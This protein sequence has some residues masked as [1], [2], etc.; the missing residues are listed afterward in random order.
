MPDHA[1]LLAHIVAQTRQ[2]VEFLVAQGELSRPDGNVILNK[3]PTA[4]DIS[5]RE[6][7]DNTRRMALPEAPAAPS[8]PSMP[9]VNNARSPPPP[10]P[11]R[12]TTQARTLWAYNE[13]GSEPNDLSFRAGDVIEIVDETNADWWTGRYNGR[14]GL[15]PSN[16][17]E[18]IPSSSPPSYP[19][20]NNRTFSAPAGPPSNQNYSNTGYASPPPPNP[21]YAGPPPPQQYGAPAPYQQYPQ[22]VA[23]PPPQQQVVQEAPQQQKPSRFGG[24]GLGNLLATSAVGGVG[25][26]AG[27]AVGSGIVNAIF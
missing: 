22:Q 10:A 21:G 3:L 8:I 6:L 1:A 15:F 11:T 7:S 26:G 27:S 13:D 19:P 5:V 9:V 2:N 24:G 14:E 25:F 18:K 20:P 16:Y 17:V 12:R 23:P 4:S